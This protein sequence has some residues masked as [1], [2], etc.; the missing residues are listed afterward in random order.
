MILD[1]IR[2][3]FPALERRHGGCHVAYFDGPGGTQVPRVVVE[4]MTDYLLRHNANTHW[5][6]PSSVETDD[7]LQQARQAGADFLNAAPDEISFGNNMT[8]I[9]FHLARALGRGWREGDEVVVTELD[10]HANVAPWRD[11]A[12]ERGLVVRTVPM[13]ADRGTLDWDAFRAALNRR[14]RLVAI[15]AAS[16]ALGTINDVAAAVALAHEAGA[17]A[18]VDAVHYA[19]HE[20]SDVRAWDCDALACSAYKFYGPHVGM[21]FVKRPLLESLDLP[22]LAPAP[23]ESPERAET[24]TQNHEGIVG[25]DAAIGFIASLGQGQSARARIVSAV[26]GLKA[27]AD[28]LLERLWDGLAGVPGVQM[29]GLPPGERRTPTVAFIVH[30]TPAGKVARRLAERGVFVSH[31]GFYATTVIERL[32]QAADGVV[33]AGLACY[34]SPNEVDRLVDGVREIAGS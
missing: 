31:G 11:V 10:H 20:L 6:Y 14:T 18:F 9:T 3:Q 29:F 23:N 21:C 16:N 33:R 12:R 24:G 1:R 4:A 34:T 32:G 22:K 8:T 19:A 17:L 7:L 30:G 25:T 27:R 26:G 15:G 28:A 2:A 5:N 13:H